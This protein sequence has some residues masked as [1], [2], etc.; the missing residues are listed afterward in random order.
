MSFVVILILILAVICL[1][2]KGQNQLAANAKWRAE[3]LS[4]LNTQSQEQNREYLARE[5]NRLQ[6]NSQK[7]YERWK[8]A[9]ILSI[10]EAA[11]RDAQSGIEEWKKDHIVE[12]REDAIK[13]SK[14]VN[15][16][17]IAEQFAPH[18]DGFN[19][20]PK[21]A[22]FVGKPFDYIIFDGLDE[23]KLKEI[24]ILEVKTGKATHNAREVQVR[25]CVD[26][27]RIRYETFRIK[28]QQCSN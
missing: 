13:K 25:T 3:T 2:V 19:Y 23:G 12:Q 24:V 18:L 7:D 28:E 26:E 1:Y 27:K 9:D 16:G 10:R 5:E 14:A 8:N 6:I 11:V 22:H 20:N 17:M 4:V 15:R 21:D